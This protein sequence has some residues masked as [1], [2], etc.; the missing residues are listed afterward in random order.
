M[1]DQT[2]FVP[3]MKHLKDKVAISLPQFDVLI[4]Q[5]WDGAVGFGG[6]SGMGK[7][8]WT[9][10]GRMVFELDA[11]KKVLSSWPLDWRGHPRKTEVFYLLFPFPAPHSFEVVDD[12]MN[13]FVNR[14]FMPDTLFGWRDLIYSLKPKDGG[15]D[16]HML[17]NRY[18]CDDLMAFNYKTERSYQGLREVL[19]ESYTEWGGDA[20]VRTFKNEFTM[21]F[22][23]ALARGIDYRDYEK[24]DCLPEGG[25]LT[26]IAG[27][28]GD[29]QDLRCLFVD[30]GGRKLMR[31]VY[32][33]DG[34]EIEEAGLKATKLVTEQ[35]LS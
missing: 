22:R 20:E 3:I 29:R 27:V 35:L 24:V 15:F 19:A 2:T 16:V 30:E 31:L 9:G 34:Y 21:G 12:V 25:K 18:N 4:E 23:E 14:A 13:D 7:E 17:I 5:L 11:L 10:D 1:E 6:N 32:A 8:T 26:A 33:K 28:W